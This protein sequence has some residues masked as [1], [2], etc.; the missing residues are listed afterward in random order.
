MRQKELKGRYGDRAKAGGSRRIKQEQELVFSRVGTRLPF[1]N[2]TVESE[3][4]W[5]RRA[6]KFD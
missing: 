5:S 2:N 6:S 1:K 3:L 4:G